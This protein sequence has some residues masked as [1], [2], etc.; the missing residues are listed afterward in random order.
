LTLAMINVV[1]GF[2]VTNRMLSMIA[3]KKRGGA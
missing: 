1:G 3:G 2:A